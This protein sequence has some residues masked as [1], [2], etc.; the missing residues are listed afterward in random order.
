M[1]DQISTDQSSV[2]N[3]A[4]DNK[5]APTK[6]ITVTKVPFIFTFPNNE[7]VIFTE[8]GDYEV[9][10][11]LANHWYTQHH[12]A[13]KDRNKATAPIP[14]ASTHGEPIKMYRK[15]EPVPDGALLPDAMKMPD[16][17]DYSQ[18]QT[19]AALV[20][21]GDFIAQQQKQAADEKARAEADAKAAADKAA[22]ED[23]KK[24]AKK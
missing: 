17:P 14:R 4:A 5:P 9:P 7:K 10:E 6:S 24:T 18:P 21:A 11:F 13:H 22:A 16:G 3:P 12:I 15:G 23:A 8:P 1:P 2:I 20:P 19:D